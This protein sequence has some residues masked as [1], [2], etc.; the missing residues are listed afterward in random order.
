MNNLDQTDDVFLEKL[1]ESRPVVNKVAEY[2]KRHGFDIKVCPELARPDVSQREEYSDDGDIHVFL[3][4]ETKRIDVKGNPK[5]SFT[6]NNWPGGGKS[7]GTIICESVHN[8]DNKGTY[9]KIY[10]V[11]KELNCAIVITPAESRKFWSKRLVYE[12]SSRRKK[13]Y[14]FCPINH[15]TFINLDT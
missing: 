13:W 1:S 3:D 2:L 12:T 8:I 6:M 7:W 14:Y 15:V 4:G 10:Q 11:N 5:Y 9:W